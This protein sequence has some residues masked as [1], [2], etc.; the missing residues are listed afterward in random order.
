VKNIAVIQI[1]SG[2]FSPEELEG[3]T[4][5]RGIDEFTGKV[6][7][8]L[9]GALL[10]SK[11]ECSAVKRVFKPYGSGFSAGDAAGRFSVTVSVDPEA[12]PAATLTILAEPCGQAARSWPSFEPRLRIAVEGEFPDYK[13]QWMTVDEFIASGQTAEPNPL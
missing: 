1:P 7:E 3:R 9:R 6:A 13:C 8:R 11:L 10:L 4:I 5:P 12:L 2:T